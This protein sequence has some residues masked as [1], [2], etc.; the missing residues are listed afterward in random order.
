MYLSIDFLMGCTLGN[1]LAA[2]DS[3]HNVA[4]ALTER[5]AR[6]EDVCDRKAGAALGNGGLG[7]LAACFSDSMATQ[8][9]PSFGYGIR[10]EYGRFA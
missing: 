8:G 5:A 1:A 7:R 4:A 2:L 10:Y 9:L 3:T 6:I